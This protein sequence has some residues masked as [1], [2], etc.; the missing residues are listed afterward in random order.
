MPRLTAQDFAP[1]VLSLFDR[2][3]HG[4][5]TRREFLDRSTRHA[6]SAGTT[7][8]ALL[9]ALSPDF[10]H[11]QKVSPTDPRLVSQT[12]EVPSPHGNG[13]IKG[14]LVR[15][16]VPAHARRPGVLVIHENRGLNPH[17]EDIARR[18]ALEGF[19]AFAPDAL[20]SLGGYPGD[21]DAAREHF[22]KLDPARNL[23]DFVAACEHLHT[24]LDCTGRVGAIGFC[25]GGGVTN[26][27]ATRV[28]DLA[29]AVP[30]YGPAPALPMVP[31]IKA[32]LQL[33]FAG[34]DA[35]INATWPPYEAALQLHRIPFEAHVYPGVQHGF[36]NDTTPRFDERAAA[37]AWGRA[38]AFLKQHATT[39]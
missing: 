1:E 16:T 32:P 35:R 39:G 33:H 21:E 18:L 36:N 9:A 11:A 34:E 7:S 13:S 37:L 30:F 5:I 12:I 19:L 14:L 28:A 31:L 24:R 10:A 22:A 23:E 27:L 38:V 25:Y 3:V 8:A 17:I 29:A 2:Y 20:T 15:L 26:V 6:V 4:G